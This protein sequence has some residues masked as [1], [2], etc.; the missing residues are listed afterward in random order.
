MN[1]MN[2]ATSNRI[3]KLRRDGYAVAGVAHD[4]VVIL[5]S[6]GRATHFTDK[7][8]DEA[9]ASLRSTSGQTANVQSDSSKFTFAKSK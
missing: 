6:R 7:Q 4:G 9:I 5:R 1:G 8:L 2:K 3:R